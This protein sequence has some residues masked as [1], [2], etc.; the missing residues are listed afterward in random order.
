MCPQMLRYGAKLSARSVTTTGIGTTSAGLTV[1]V[2]R[3]TGGGTCCGRHAESIFD[4]CIMKP[5]HIKL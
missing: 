5:F 4:I 2:V 3:D 1:S